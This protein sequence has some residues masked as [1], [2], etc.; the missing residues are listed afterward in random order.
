MLVTHYQ[1]VSS[2]ED[3]FI[4]GPANLIYFPK[5]LS[6]KAVWPSVYAAIANSAT[7]QNVVTR[8]K[9][10]YDNRR[11]INL[12][13]NYR[14]TLILT[15]PTPTSCVQIIDGQ[16]PELSTGE[17]E[18]IVKMAPFS[19]VDQILVDEE[20]HTPPQVIF[21]VEPPHDWCYFY[22]KASLARQRGDWQTVVDLGEQAFKEN[23]KAADAIEWMPFL[24]GY[25]IT[26]NTSRVAQIAKQ[27]S[28]QPAVRAQ[29][30]QILRQMSGLS[31]DA[32]KQIQTLFCVP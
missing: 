14:N 8:A 24:Q 13:M 4:W 1:A 15:Q 27:L 2:E 6:E 17:W 12:Y 21:G 7:V 22:E 18:Y 31:V 23:Y 10:G 5:K 29:A 11:T 30:C 28:T 26:N 3:Y 25:A 32:Q 19:R 20:T 9:Q 16:Q